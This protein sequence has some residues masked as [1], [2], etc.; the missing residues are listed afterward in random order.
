MQLLIES[1]KLENFLSHKNTEVR[2]IRGVNVFIGPNGAGKS[3]I[4]EA[5][6]FA[7]TGKGWRTSRRRELINKKASTATVELEFTVGN[8]KYLVR[9]RIG[10]SGTILFKN[11]KPLARDE[12]KVNEALREILGVHISKLE[13]IVLIPQGALTRTFIELAPKDRKETIDIL[14]GLHEYGEAGEKLKEVAFAVKTKYPATITPL[15]SSELR[16]YVQDLQNRVNTDYKRV[17]MEIE[18]LRRSIEADKK[19]I[20]EKQETI[21]REKLEE[22]AARVEELE[23]L[24]SELERKIGMIKQSINM[25]KEEN[26]E[27]NKKIDEKRR[28]L[29]E[30]RE[31]I[32]QIEQR[33]AI[34]R[35]ERALG[36]VIDKLKELPTLKQLYKE[37]LD[38]LK[39]LDETL[40]E[41]KSLEKKY[42]GAS[43]KEL[44]EKKHEVEKK[45]EEI[46]ARIRK[47]ASDKASIST[48]IK[49]YNEK[50]M[51]CN[52]LINETIGKLRAKGFKVDASNLIK[53]I[54]DYISSLEQEKGEVELRKT[55]VI[56]EI[57]NIDIMVS[58]YTRKLD[59]IRNTKE[60]KC[61]L[62][63]RP[64]DDKHRN[65]II[66]MF[67][68]EIKELNRRREKLFKQLKELKERGKHI[69]TELSEITKI[70]IDLLEDKVKE[71][72]RLEEAIEKL[73]EKLS[74]LKKE[75]EKLITEKEKLRKE[76]IELNNQL[77][78]V[79]KL[80]G[81]KASYNAEEHKSLAEKKVSLERKIREY[82]EVIN[83]TI[84]L[85]N[86]ELGLGLSINERLAENLNKMIEEARGYKEEEAS[87][88]TKIEQ[89]SREIN[90]LTKKLEENSGRIRKLEKDEEKLIAEN[91]RVK[92]DLDKAVEAK[93]KLEKLRNEISLLKER[94]EENTRKLAEKEEEIREIEKSV[95]E[96]N[97]ALRK[98]GVVNW[99]RDNLFH[100]DG[101]PKLLRRRYIRVLESIMEE[102]MNRFGLEYH[103]VE[104]DEDYSIRLRSINYPDKP[105][106]IKSLSGG[107]QVIVSLVAMLALYKLVSGGRIGFLALDEPTEHLDEERRGDLIEVL[108]E[109]QGGRII[110]QLI[111]VTHDEKVR[112]SGDKIYRVSKV[113]GFSRVEEVEIGG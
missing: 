94:V 71:R 75:E 109:F 45:L 12:N 68:H 86:K 38:R 67:E 27:L 4:L 87:L 10:G 69:D 24:H 82:E 43:S 15:R 96:I 105:V 112:D 1:V 44:L 50:L 102:L 41:I 93:S 57:K 111:V 99:I 42:H 9:R 101:V 81:L 66:L 28:E 74:I 85:I 26:N 36:D 18:E 77:I 98:I 72:E 54:K 30:A 80:E 88:K 19:V 59:L 16:R 22:K 17:V 34:L 20:M 11:G 65:E 95:K 14:L 8:D 106:P 97:D 58:D 2:F 7:L 25:L 53:I 113:N 70:P 78:N 21:A 62:C 29:A 33:I 110:P 37:V 6:Y 60:P 56:S 47:Y 35:Y 46:D 76:L 23:K 83:N 55:D 31:R 84:A 40:A 61:P 49:N 107:E 3:S 64:L 48:D 92:R 5:I 91:Q 100:R 89:I 39:K 103:G 79:T 104:I 90:D 32:K 73:K 52:K 63:G 51:E 13:S 108:R